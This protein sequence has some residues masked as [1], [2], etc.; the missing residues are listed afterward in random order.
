MLGTSF[1]WNCRSC[2]GEMNL[3]PVLYHHGVTHDLKS[4][5]GHILSHY[6]YDE[7]VLV[8]FSMG[9]NIIFKYLG[10]QGTSVSKVITKAVAFSVPCHLGSS[11]EQI[12][13]KE[14]KVYKDRFLKKLKGK[15]RQKG[16]Q[17]PELIDLNGI[18]QILDFRSFD[19]KYTAPLHGFKDA[20][21]FL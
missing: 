1:V 4:V 13:L 10:E 5:I 15:V 8:G 6:G 21:H 17:Y 19:T 18:D 20:D 3:Q 16:D 2:S 9:G 11:V 12:E 14:N 7:V